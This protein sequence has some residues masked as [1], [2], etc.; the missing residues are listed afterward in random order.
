MTELE[1]ARA[2]LAPQGRLRAAI[3][4]GNPVLAARAADGTLSGVTVELATAFARA[5]GAGLDLVPYDG[6][7]KVVA[8]AGDDVWDVAF[9][10]LDPQRGATLAY[11]RPYV[12]IEGVFAVRRDAPF[13]APGDLDRA[14]VVIGVGAGAAYDLYLS[15]EFARATLRRYPTS[16]AVLPA[17]LA[18]GLDAGAGIRQPV[19]AFVAA[20]P[21]LRV[22]PD[23]FMTIAQAVAVPRAKA[24]ALGWLQA[25][26][27]RL[28]EAGLIRAALARAGQ[29]PGLADG[30]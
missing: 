15:R 19:E 28:A 10:A 23:A 21:G 14:G 3:N 5:L 9:L 1:T 11:T 13:A 17:I 16:A 18:D 29:E 26:L 22:V 7:G 24:G 20:T 4:C 12:R 6:A 2:L 27:D 30:V 25:E 8:G